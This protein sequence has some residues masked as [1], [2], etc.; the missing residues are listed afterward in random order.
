MVLNPMQSSTTSKSKRLG[1]LASELGSEAANIRDNEGEAANHG[2]YFDD[3][4]YDYMQ[5]LR[6][7]GSGSGEAVWIDPT[8]SLNKDK[9]KHKESL[10]DALG[11]MDLRD[12]S[13][14]LLDD[15]ILPS[16]HLQRVSYQAQQNVPDSIAGF[17]PDMDP[18]LREVLE[19][20]EDDAYVGDDEDIFKELAEDAQELDDDEF[21]DAYPE[22]DDGWESDDTAKPKNEYNYEEVPQLVDVGK[23]G[24][25][26]RDDAWFAEFRKFQKEQKAGKKPVGLAR[27]DVE[28]SLMTTTTNGGRHKKRK[29]ALTNQSAYSMTSAS[30]VRTEQ[31]TILDSRFDVL[32]EKAYG[33]DTDDMAS[34][35]ALS[36]V[37]S[38]QGPLRSDFDDIMDDFLGNYSMQGKRKVKKGKRQTGLEQLDEIR[39]EL[40]PARVLT[41]GE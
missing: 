37:S 16:K 23:E 27:T 15:D 35:S 10:A 25:H 34:V 31:L 14:Q 5:H 20:L 17:Q 21:A 33:D 11:A 24:D 13:E 38:V 28:S 18:R 26:S 7:L 6:D 39:R 22:D 19:A 4:K 8:A 30:L 41:G 29:G 36:T 9:G 32:E 12:R 2:V 1:D 3:S 40:G